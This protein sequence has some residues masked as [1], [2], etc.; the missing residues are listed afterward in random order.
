[1]M[2]K[3]NI[4]MNIIDNLNLNDKDLLC[5]WKLYKTVFFNLF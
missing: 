5:D 1:M 4:K 3:K 2:K